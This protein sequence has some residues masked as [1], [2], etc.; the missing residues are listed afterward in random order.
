MKINFNATDPTEVAIHL[1]YRIIILEAA[2]DKLLDFA[3][4]GT[5]TQSDLDSARKEAIEKLQKN[6]L[7]RESH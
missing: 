5:F 1:E 6:I 4:P 3:P 2:I 7:R